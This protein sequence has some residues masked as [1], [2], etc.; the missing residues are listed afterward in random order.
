MDSVPPDA[1]SELKVM[2][3]TFKHKISRAMAAMHEQEALLA[4]LLQKKTLTSDDK[5]T[6]ASAIR[7]AVRLLDDAAPFILQTFG[8]NVEK[9]VAKGRLEVESFI[10]LALHRVGIKAVHDSNGVLLL[11]TGQEATTKP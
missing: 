10:Q 9:M 11:G 7:E 4:T 2:A 1:G 3:D 5:K 8:E 6:I